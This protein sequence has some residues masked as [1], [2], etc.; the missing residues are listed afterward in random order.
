[1]KFGL[2][3][4]DIERLEEGQTVRFVIPDLVQPGYNETIEIEPADPDNINEYENTINRA[5]LDEE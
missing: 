4:G 5:D 3:E 2:T 1:M